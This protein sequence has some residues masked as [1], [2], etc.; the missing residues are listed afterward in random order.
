[1]TSDVVAEERSAPNPPSSAEALPVATCV[2]LTKTYKLAMGH[3]LTALSKLNLEVSPN[4]IFGI[5]GPNGSG[6]TTT[7]KLLLGLIFPTS[8]FCTIMG[9]HPRSPLSKQSVGFMPEG[10]FFYQ[11]LNGAEIIQFFG[12]LCGL[13]GRELRDRTEELLQL[14]GMSARR[15][16][17]ISQCSKGMVQRIGL[18][19][20]MVNDPDLVMMDEPTSGLD[21]IGTRE[22]KDLIVELR[23]RGKTVLVCSHLLEQVQEMCDRV[24]IL[25]RGELL[26][27]GRVD[28]I[29]SPVDESEVIV[30]GASEELVAKLGQMGVGA[31][32]ARRDACFRVPSSVPIFDVLSVIQ[33]SGAELL[34]VSKFQE[35][36]ET[37]FLRAVTTGQADPD[38]MRG[39]HD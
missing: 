8:G 37:V 28:E 12:Q 7:L 2:E 16:V 14:V 23:S 39:E 35:T 15:R 29:L 31:D 27:V 21:P 22:I 13:G 33:A 34:S 18:A 30:G 17:V 9:H 5:V 26:R 10:P 24:A 3:E 1:L 36:L 32:T 6:K 38:D 20:A 19:A 25:H 11:H 4:E